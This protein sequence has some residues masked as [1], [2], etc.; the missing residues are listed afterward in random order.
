MIQK[1]VHFSRLAAVLCLFL[2]LWAQVSF[3]QSRGITVKGSIMDADG[4]PVI[5]AGVV[6]KGTSTGVAAAADGSFSINVPG[7][8]S[9]LEISALGYVTQTVTV[10]KQRSFTIVLRDDSESL[11]A[12]VVVAYGTQTRATVT[13]ALTTI[14]SKAL[15]KAPVADV[16]NV[17]AGQMPGVATVQYSGQPGEDY[18]EIFIRGRF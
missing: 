11:E 15:V 4:L 16:A 6:L 14:D 3:A 1:V 9:V 8:S 7:E 5:G 18:A 10:G 13:G 12:T 17:L 2:G